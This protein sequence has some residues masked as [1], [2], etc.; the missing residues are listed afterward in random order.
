M[1]QRPILI[2]GI[3]KVALGKHNEAIGD[4]NKAI[5]LNPNLQRHIIIAG[6]P[7]EIWVNTMRL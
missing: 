7:R 1:M 2:A 5:E 4:F 3:V 6:L